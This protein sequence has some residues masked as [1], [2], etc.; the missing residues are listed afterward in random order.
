MNGGC[1]ILPKLCLLGLAGFQT[2]F[3]VATV[4]TAGPD[5]LAPRGRPHRRDM[6]VRALSAHMCTLSVATAHALPTAHTLRMA[7]S[8]PLVDTARHTQVR[9]ALPGMAGLLTLGECAARVHR[10]GY[11]S[12]AELDLRK[13]QLKDVNAAI[14]GLQLEMQAAGERVSSACVGCVLRTLME[15]PH[16]RFAPCS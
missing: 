8:T 12:K 7:E 2:V 9:D 16:P 3:E 11:Q 14:Q 6:P 13:Q 10:E 4:C 1:S 5:A 15:Q